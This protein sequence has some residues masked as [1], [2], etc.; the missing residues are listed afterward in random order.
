VTVP[1]ELYDH[2]PS[3]CSIHCILPPEI[4]DQIILK[5]DAGQRARALALKGI[6]QT[7][8]VGRIG[9]DESVRLERQAKRA[10]R[11]VGR[12][13]TGWFAALAGGVPNRTI[14]NANNH[15]TVTGPVVRMEGAPATGDLATDEAYDYMGA[16]YDFFWSVYN[17]D[18]I[19]D[20]GM[21]LDGTVHYGQNY[22]N[23]FWDGQRMIYG[24]GDKV[25]FE[26]FTKC[27]D[28]I[29]HELMH[30]VIQHEA[31]LIYWGQSGALNESI[32]DVFGSLVKQYHLNQTASQADWLIGKGLFIPGAVVNGVAIRSMKAPG[33]AYGPDPVM[34][35]DEQPAHM[36]QYRWTL[37][38]NGGV[39][40]NS[41]IPNHAFYLAAIKVGGY[42][43]DSVGWI[44]YETLLR[45][46]LR[47]VTNFSTFAALTVDTAEQLYPAGPEPKA[48][49]DA[50]NAVG[51]S[52]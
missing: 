22:D 48:V 39:H 40:I 26:R 38:D 14:R 6:N 33:T 34:G 12:A 21:P 42:A 8:S 51:V 7:L 19:D 27:I 31:G 23:A 10:Q 47:K 18:S 32:A 36:D 43:W 3:R 1:C 5:G 2:L 25:D 20:E 24:D 50:W 45:P 9:F 11:F 16:T 44:W 41:G 30:G 15:N 13:R 29:G 35:K 52:V 28:V 17:R 46:D 4:L 37:Q 49:S